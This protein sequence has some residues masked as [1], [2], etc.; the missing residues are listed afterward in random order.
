[1]KGLFLQVKLTEEAAEVLVDDQEIDDLNTLQYLNKD[2]ATTSIAP[3]VSLVEVTMAS[4]SPSW[5]RRC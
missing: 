1:M 3:S 5:P 4:L 2:M